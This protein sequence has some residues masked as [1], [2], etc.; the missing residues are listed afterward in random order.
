MKKAKCIIFDCDGVLVNSEIIGIR[1]LISMAKEFGLG[2][3]LPDAIKKFRGLSLKDS[4]KKVEELIDKDLP[5][6]FEKEYRRLT[7][8]AFRSE[9]KPIDGIFEF[10]EMLCIPFCVASSGPVE[11]IRLNLSLVGLL[12]KFENK[13]F[14]SFKINSWKPSPEIFLHA[15]KEMKFTPDECIVIEDSKPGVM[16]AVTGGFKVFGLA[17]EHTAKELESAGAIIFYNFNELSNLLTEAEL[18]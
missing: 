4:F 6:N 5:D 13:I 8:N 16:A 18:I 17:D 10:I 14:S 1:V 11:K 15:A 7:Y 9:L 2:I 3:D 12:E